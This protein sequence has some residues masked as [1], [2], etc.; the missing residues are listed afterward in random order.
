MQYGTENNAGTQMTTL[1]TVAGMGP[2]RP[3]FL[4]TLWIRAEATGI[5]LRVEGTDYG[6]YSVGR[7]LGV[8]GFAELVAEQGQ[9][10]RP[11]VLGTGLVG[12][13]G[14]SRPSASARADRAGVV[15]IGQGIDSQGVIGQA[16]DGPQAIG[17]QGWSESGTAG[18]F[19]GDVAIVPKVLQ[20][21][22][23][24]NLTV[25]RTVTK[26]GG[27]FKIDHPLAPEDKY[28]SHSFV[29]SPE[30][31]NVYSGNTTTDE[32]GDATVTLPEYFEALN[33]DFCYQL[34]V[35]GDLAHAVVAEEI[36]DNRFKIKTDRP[37]VKVSW[38]V[39]GVRKDAFAKQYAMPVE[40]EKSS[41]ERGT[42]LH[43]EAFGQPESRGT[44]YARKHALMEGLSAG[45]DM[46]EAM[47]EE[48]REPLG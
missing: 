22:G 46:P 33:E 45:P 3:A 18:V 40:E 31:L 29:E 11:G 30:A 9:D 32:S 10:L 20:P 39:T 23:G 38:Q 19:Y 7:L 34:T 41:E 37:N 14:I 1:R 42:Y 35:I 47:P 26:G 17:V 36:R 2:S 5:G 24:G 27:G 44:G 6:V 15:G 13:R 28:L 43:P 8:G 12:V 16:N 21:A 4:V 48:L 25:S